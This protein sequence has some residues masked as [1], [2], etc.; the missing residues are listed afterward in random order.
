MI[1]L[2][3]H[4]QWTKSTYSTGNGACVEVRSDE[5]SVLNVKD[6]KVDGGPVLNVAPGAWA[7]FVTAVRN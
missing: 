6:S 1:K 3:S 7:A 4:R 5:P 2:G